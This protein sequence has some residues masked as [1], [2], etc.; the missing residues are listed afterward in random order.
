A[1]REDGRAPEQPAAPAHPP[2][3][4]RAAVP[5]EPGVDYPDPRPRRVGDKSDGLGSP[6]RVL[7][8]L[9][10]SWQ[11]Q[12]WVEYRLRD[13]ARRIQW[14]TVEMR[15]GQGPDQPPHLEVLLWTDVPTQGMIPARSSLIMDDV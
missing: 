5:G 11:G 4:A 10:V 9:R 14:L 13:S 1:H 6:V 12:Q 2:P 7:G 3:R 8:A 15:Q